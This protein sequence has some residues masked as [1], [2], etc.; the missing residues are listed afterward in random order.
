MLASFGVG[1]S[2]ARPQPGGQGD[3]WRAAGVILKPVDDVDAAAW[4]AQVLANVE[5][6]GFRISRPVSAV[7]GRF[8]VDGWT[9]WSVVEG[10]HD[11]TRRWPEVIRTGEALH[12]A[13]AGAPRPPFLDRRT[14][15]WAIGDRVAWDAQPFEVHDLGL[16]ALAVRLR[17]YVRPSAEPSQ[18][19]HGDLSGNVL[20]HEDLVPAIIDFTPYWRPALFSLAVVA[21]DAVS[22]YGANGTLFDALPDHPDRASMLAR[23]GMYRLVTSDQAAMLK[24]ESVRATYL[25]ENTASFA[26]LLTHLE[27]WCSEIENQS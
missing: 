3:A 21:V 23:A 19:V 16:C 8:V 9:A 4:T 10:T 24:P 12:E 1:G 18:L 17:R 6:R 14:D 2:E 22:W 13:L 20:F 7:D 11:L 25:A 27:G 5:E 15:V 26:R